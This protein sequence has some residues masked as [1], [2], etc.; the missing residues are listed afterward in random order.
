MPTIESLYDG[1]A[2]EARGVTVAEG[3][4]P[5]ADGHADGK[6]L[7]I[8]ATFS[9]GDAERFGLTVRTGKGEQTVIGYDTRTRELYVDRTRSGAVDF[10]DD[11]PGVQRAPLSP[12]ADGR[13]ELRVLVDWSSVEVF[14]GAGEAVITDQIFPGPS[15]DGLRLFAEGGTAR[16]DAATVRQVRSYRD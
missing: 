5:L 3:S 11:F 13:I 7:D 2:V 14:G 15:S 10:H 12:R 6:A 9:P 4:A 16:L 1:P 8:R